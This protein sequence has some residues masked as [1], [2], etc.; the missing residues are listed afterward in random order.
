MGGGQDQTHLQRP[1]KRAF[2]KLT[3]RRMEGLVVIFPSV[4]FALQ[5][6]SLLLTESINPPRITRTRGTETTRSPG[7]TRGRPNTAPQTSER[8][9]HSC[10]F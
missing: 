8:Q 6:V 5:T 10:A 3:A 1:N 7:A 4:V 9:L 2:V